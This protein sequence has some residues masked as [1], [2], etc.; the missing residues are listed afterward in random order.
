MAS[1]VQRSY[2]LPS[3]GLFCFPKDGH[4]VTKFGVYCNDIDTVDITLTTFGQLVVDQEI[5]TNTMYSFMANMIRLGYHQVWLGYECLD[6]ATI[7]IEYATFHCR[8]NIVADAQKLPG[9]IKPILW[10]FESDQECTS[11]TQDWNHSIPLA[12]APHSSMGS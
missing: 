10:Y 8:E 3:D 11:T 12:T 5:Q 1:F 2:P 9:E 7:I 4:V 6:S